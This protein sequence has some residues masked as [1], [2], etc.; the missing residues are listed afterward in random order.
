[1]GIAIFHFLIVVLV[2]AAAIFAPVVVRLTSGDIS[3]PS[4][5]AAAREFLVLHGRI[6]MPLIGAFMLLVLHNIVVTHRVAGPL[7]R[8]RR[9][10]RGVGQGDLSAGIRIRKADYLHKEAK[11]ASRMVDALREKVVYIEERYDEAN[12]AWRELRCALS[13]ETTAGLEGKIKALSERLEDCRAGVDV[14]NTGKRRSY[15]PRREPEASDDP[16]EVGA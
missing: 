12:E 3:S 11:A 7:F 13:G 16:V 5:Q 10:M 6:W 8:F 1:V 4:V 2:F 15:L 9:Y 14:F